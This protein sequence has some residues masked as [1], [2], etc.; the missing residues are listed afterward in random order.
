MHRAGWI[1]HFNQPTISFFY[2]T[3]AME[4]IHVNTTLVRRV[5]KKYRGT[6]NGIILFTPR[7]NN[8]GMNT[9]CRNSFEILPWNRTDRVITINFFFFRIISIIFMSIISYQDYFFFRTFR[10][11]SNWTWILLAILNLKVF[12]VLLLVKAGKLFIKND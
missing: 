1:Y 7:R 3:D 5:K 9:L 11:F 10:T 12:S 6:G 4:I 8:S 2:R